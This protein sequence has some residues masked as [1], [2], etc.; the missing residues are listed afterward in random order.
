MGF[1][2]SIIEKVAGYFAAF[3]IGKQHEKK[4]QTERELKDAKKEVKRLASRP[5][6]DDDF[7]RLLALWERHTDKK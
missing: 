2:V 7:D 6:T 3:F 1:L 4:K 5:R